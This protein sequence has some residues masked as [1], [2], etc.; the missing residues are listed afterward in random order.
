MSK[1]SGTTG[2]DDSKINTIPARIKVLREAVGVSAAQLDR[3]TGL[4]AGT[5]GRLE[6]GDQRVYGSHLYRIAQATGVDVGWFYRESHDAL[7]EGSS[8]VHET[9]CLVD[10]YM[11]I[12]DPGLKR[13][14][15]ELIETLAKN[16]TP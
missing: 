10:A 11:R 4:A 12:S 8:P 15:F 3:Q 6:R 5:T 7:V 1:S 2:I 14:V 13:D 16:P 9:Q